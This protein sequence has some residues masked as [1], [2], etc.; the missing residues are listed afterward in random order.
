MDDM[1]LALMPA[2]LG[3]QLRDYDHHNGIAG[4]ESYSIFSMS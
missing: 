2:G 1:V 3:L 4:T